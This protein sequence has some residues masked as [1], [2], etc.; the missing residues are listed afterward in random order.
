MAAAGL[1]AAVAAPAGELSGHAALATEY[2]YRGLALSDHNPA[3]QVGID[4]ELE[5]G[6]FAGAWASTIDL[7]N[8]G[9][10]RDVELDY[11]V[12]W[13]YVPEAPVEVTLSLVRY[14][15]P[16]QTG[17]FDYD[18]TEA[19]ATA[20]IFERYSVEIG[21]SGSI[22]GWDGATGRHVEARVDWPLANAWVIGAGLGYNDVEDLGMSN[23]LY[24]DLGASARYSRLTV[25]LR[26][27]DNEPAYGTLEGLAA[28]SRLVGT[29][30]VAF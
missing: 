7:S 14:T 1:A 28:G 13:H 23:Y 12:G 27:Y 20:S 5:S 4:Y 19:L 21:Y 17:Y 29:L 8:P 3:F 30:S 10:R 11:Y 6:L 22:Y 16:G 26:W 15:Y 24:W 2:V 9:G 18:Y 25:D